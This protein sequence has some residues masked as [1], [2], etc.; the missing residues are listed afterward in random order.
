[1]NNFWKVL[2]LFFLG[3]LVVLIVTHGSGFAKSAGTLF[4]GV[5]ALGTTLTGRGPG[6]GGHAVST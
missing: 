2:T 3:C 1:M 6:Q 4:N 5:N